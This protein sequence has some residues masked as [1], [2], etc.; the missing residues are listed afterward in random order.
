[1]THYLEHFPGDELFC[2]QIMDIKTRVE[3]HYY[4]E[5]LNFMNPHEA[6]VAQKLIGY[7]HGVGIAFNG[8]IS[9]AEM[10]RALIYPEG[11]EPQ[12]EDF[13]IAVME[14]RY[15]GKFVK[16]SHRDVLGALMHLGLKRELYGDIV[17]M[18]EAAYFAC[19]DRMSDYLI[20]N[21]KMVGRG[22]VQIKKTS[23][24]IE[25]HQD[26]RQVILSI[27]SFRLDVILS[28]AFHLSRKEAMTNIQ[29]NF[30]KVNYKEVVQ[31]N[32]LCH[33]ND[34]ISLRRHGR[35][36]LIDLEKVNRKGKHV[37]EVWFYK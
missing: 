17:V 12:P 20:A 15:P 27:A 11:Y 29:S 22:S 31:T 6:D 13:E 23:K 10:Q 8:G 18:E 3:E 9:Q 7:H 33:N 25:H 35:V 4:P 24:V 5:L 16:I 36:K 21:L 14:V 26:Y 34:I 2:R 19:D 1:M 30:V 28:E 32:Y 37:I